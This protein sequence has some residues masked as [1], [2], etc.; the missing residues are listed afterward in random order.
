MLTAKDE[1]PEEAAA[2][3]VLRR[4]ARNMVATKALRSELRSCRS[5]RRIF[6]ADDEVRLVFRPEAVREKAEQRPVEANDTREDT[7][8]DESDSSSECTHHV[9]VETVV[10]NLYVRLEA[11]NRA[12]RDK[13]A[14]IYQLEAR[15]AALE[16]E[17]QLLRTALN[18]SPSKGVDTLEVTKILPVH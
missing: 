1:H 16:R 13:D 11:S 7:G 12:Q 3:D 4:F 18:K 10:H 8:G 17:N 6:E 5:L 15:V 9:T 14:Y 2:Q